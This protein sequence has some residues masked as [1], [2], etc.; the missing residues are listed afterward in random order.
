MP[1]QKVDK[2]RK[3]LLANAVSNKR[4]LMKKAKEDRKEWLNN[5]AIDKRELKE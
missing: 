2:D 1:V 4:D 3:E 5:A